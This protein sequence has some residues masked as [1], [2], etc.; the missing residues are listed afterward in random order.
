MIPRPG[1]LQG[2]E[3][4]IA[5][6]L[7]Y[8]LGQGQELYGRGWSCPSRATVIL[9]RPARPTRVEMS[10]AEAL[11]S[12]CEANKNEGDGG[13]HYCDEN[14]KAGR[15]SRHTHRPTDDVLMP[16][17]LPHEPIADEGQAQKDRHPEKSQGRERVVAVPS[18][19][20]IASLTVGSAMEPLRVYVWQSSSL[21]VSR[22][23][24]LAAA[25][26]GGIFGC[27]KLGRQQRIDVAR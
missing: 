5:F 21:A 13:A 4:G 23:K 15:D 2:V 7:L 16:V 24:G 9:A 26:L 17:R 10:I 22:N 20:D 18:K 12:P 25:A 1:V 11:K 14:R 19:G 27:R 6:A 8:A 3:A